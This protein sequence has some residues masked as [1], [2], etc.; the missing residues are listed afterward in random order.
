MWGTNKNLNVVQGC[1]HFFMCMPPNWV[2]IYLSTHGANW[3]AVQ[4]C[5]YLYGQGIYDIRDAIKRLG[6]MASTKSKFRPGLDHNPA[7]CIEI[8][9]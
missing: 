7:L 3:S 1:M 6:H 8:L 4:W 5:E 2:T 9:R